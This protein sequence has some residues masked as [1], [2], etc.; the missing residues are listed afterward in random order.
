MEEDAAFKSNK[1]DLLC[2][3]NST[4]TLKNEEL[5]LTTQELYI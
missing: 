4:Y 5:S 2:V 3:C 1:R